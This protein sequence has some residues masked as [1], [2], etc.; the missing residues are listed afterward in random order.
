MI[1]IIIEK[2]LVEYDLLIYTPLLMHGNEVL[3]DI[4][5]EEISYV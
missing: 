3:M 1:I 5:L 4:I 2:V